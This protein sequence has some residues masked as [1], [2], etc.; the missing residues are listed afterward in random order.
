MYPTL[1]D[2]FLDLFG[3]SLPFLKIVQMFGFCVAMAFLGAAWTL[4]LEMKRKEKLGVMGEIQIRKYWKGRP[5]P[6]SEYI[7]SVAIGLVLGYKFV[8][9]LT[10][11]SEVVKNPQDYFLSLEGSALGAVIGAV[12]AGALK[13]WEDKQQRLDKPEQVEETVYPHQH[14]GTITIIAAIAGILGAKLFHNLENMNEFMADP[15]DAIISF[16]GLSFYG[17]LIV[18]AY[19]VIR[20]ARKNKIKLLAICDAT[21]PGLILA[22]GIGRIG[23]QVAGDGDWGLPNDNP[24]PDWL[25]WAPDWLWSYNYP[26]NVLHL[27]LKKDFASMGL[28]SISGYAYPTPIYE[29]LMSFLIFG[30]LWSIR[31]KINTPGMLFSIYLILISIERLIIES[32]RINTKYH[33]FGYE[34]TQAQFLSVVMIGLGS[35]GI[36]YFRKYPKKLADI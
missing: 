33:V 23:C 5:F 25:S 17:G 26:N 20:Y 15:L 34:F 1:Y 6:A 11:F 22:Y 36:W 8:P 12:L 3:I 31:K 32:I 2:L 4:T 24:K 30:I 18:A 29:M 7:S 21:A 28:E 16:S 13:F 19:F 35:F 14:I 9:M 27:D 10:Q